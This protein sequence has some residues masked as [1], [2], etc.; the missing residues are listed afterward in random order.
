MVR[1]GYQHM[2]LDDYVHKVRQIHRQRRARLDAIATPE[3]A[4]TYRQQVRRAVRRAFSPVPPKTPLDAR[5]TRVIEQPD[6]RIENITFESRPGCLVTANL[7]LPNELEKPAPCVLGTCGH[8]QAGKASELYQQFSRRLARAGFVVLT[9]DPFSQGERDQYHHSGFREQVGWGT[10]AH[11]MIGK[12][13][14]LLGEFFGFWRAWDGVRALDYLLDR[15][16]VDPACVGLTG[17]SGGG[18]MST[19]LWAIEDRFTMAAP[20]CFVTTFL[21]NLE[22]ELPADA[23][24]C[25]P[26]VIGAGLEMADF[27]IAAAPKPV[28]LLGQAYDFFDR[29]GLQ[30]AFA[31]VESFYA[32][33]GAPQGNTGLFI[34]PQG[35]GYSIH[36]Q[37]AMVEFFCRHAGLPVVQVDQVDVLPEQELYATP[38]GQTNEAGATPVYDL[39]AVQAREAVAKRL[40]LEPGEMKARVQVLLSLPAARALPDYRVPR[41][42]RSQD[43]VQARYAVETEPHIRAILRKLLAGPPHPFTLD[44]EP[45]IR[46][47][48]PH[49]SAEADLAENEWA[50]SLKETPM[51]CASA[52]LY[53]LDVR[54]RGESSPEE[55]REAFVQPYGMDYMFHAYGSMLGQSY[56]GRRVYDVLC[57]LDLLAHEGAESI[58]LFGRGQGAI[59]ALF[60]ALFHDRVA[61]VTLKDAPHSFFEWT[62]TPYVTWASSNFV[63]GILELCDLPDIL[64]QLGDRAQ[65]VDYW[66]P[67][68]EPAP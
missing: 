25:P 42:I 51:L 18:T 46:L 44:V 49:T 57:V 2:V 68:M 60:A 48:L 8:A 30:E 26:G 12:Q 41:P 13:L 14:E 65:I 1:N 3:Q 23:E 43:Q 54:G 61:S 47:Y 50:I 5:V 38:S 53:A 67:T 45:E 59:L 20:S 10:R 15:P 22:N 63:P 7:Y 31:D 56:L 37:Q 62:Q 36:N 52:P 55:E 19:W 9:Y 24:Q 6:C 34:G 28:L 32:R 11:N 40:R 33:M 66:G 29:R 21:R 64:E 16:E 58:H 17:N 39:I 4:L 35:H 27:I